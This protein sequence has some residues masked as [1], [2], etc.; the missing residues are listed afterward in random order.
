MRKLRQRFSCL[1]CIIALLAVNS[2]SVFAQG[3]RVRAD[4]NNDPDAVNGHISSDPNDP[5]GDHPEARDEWFRS[6]R[7]LLGEH[8]A[9]YL[10]RAYEQK[11]AM[12]AARAANRETS[13][14]SDLVNPAPTTASPGQN[15]ANGI[16]F[17]GGTYAGA[18]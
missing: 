16:A 14:S 6:G 1:F 8:A 7:R 9:D 2:G 15:T 5:D 17:S 12:A 10:H 4:R 11:R 13:R 18:W 3:A